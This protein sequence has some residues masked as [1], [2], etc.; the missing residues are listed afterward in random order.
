MI[1]CWI[2]LLPVNEGERYH[3]KCLLTLF[4]H[5]RCP[6]VTLH[7]PS[8]AEAIAEQSD[9]ISISGVQDKVIVDLDAKGECIRP[10]DDGRYILKVPAAAYKHLPENEHLSMSL[11]RLVGLS[12]PWAGLVE[13]PDGSLAYIVRRFDRTSTHPV[14][15]LRQEDFCSLSGRMPT[16]K[17]EA[18]A[19]ECAALVRQHTMDAEDSS[20]RLF[21]LFLFSFWIGNDDLHLKNLSMAQSASGG[22]TLSMA[23]DLLCTR[24]YP[25]LNKGMALPLNGRKLH[26]QRKDFR[27][28]ATTCGLEDD[29]A[30]RLIDALR[31]QRHDAEAA[32]DRSAL[33]KA[34]Q[35]HY[36]RE[37]DKKDKALAKKI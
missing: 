34:F 35:T 1:G 16:Q 4:G 22:Y 5:R 12:V 15:K 19:E 7:A 25:Q 29:E 8:V 26:H 28:F 13:M 17:Y 30:D 9:K 24:L 10:A 3:P 36:R 33:P 23:Y 14:T 2:C 27:A 21:L 18:S 32:I 37:L 31:A 11:A 20:R 6:R